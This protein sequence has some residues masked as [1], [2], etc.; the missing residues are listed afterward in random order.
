MEADSFAYLRLKPAIDSEL[1]VDDAKE[2]LSALSES[3]Q[4][5]FKLVIKSAETN[6]IQ[7]YLASSKDNLE[8]LKHHIYSVCPNV[9]IEEVKKSEAVLSKPDSTLIFKFKNHF[10]YPFY[11]PKEAD[12]EALL[13]T[14]SRVNNLNSSEQL[15]I[16]LTSATAHPIRAVFIRRR[17]L[18][19]YMPYLNDKTLK[20]YIAKFFFLLFFVLSSAFK[21][22]FLLANN[23]S[24]KPNMSRTRLQRQKVDHEE[25]VLLLDKLYEPLFKTR[26]VV[27][28]K[29][30]KRRLPKIRKEAQLALTNFAGSCGDQQLVI[31]DYFGPRDIYSLS[32]L[33][34]WLNFTKPDLKSGIY[35]VQ[36]FKTLPIP[37][38]YKSKK[39]PGDVVVGLNTYQGSM[40][41]IILPKSARY[42]HAYITGATGSG[43]S[44][45]LANLISQD[46]ASGQGATLI[47]PHGDLASE[48]MR[49][50]PG[51]RQKDVIYFDPSSVK[52]SLSINLLETRYAPGTENYTH[53]A[54][55]LTEGVISLFRKVF[56]VE[57]VSSHRLE[58]I[59]RNS[60]RTAL[61]IP[62]SN[63]F[64]I[65]K[66]LT[67]SG[68]RL[69][70]TNQLKDVNLINFWRNELGRAGE[71]QRVKMT[72]GVTSK[73]GRFLFSEPTKRVFGQ[74]KSNLDIRSVMESNKVLICNFSKGKLGEDGSRLFATAMLTKIQLAALSRADT[75]A[76]YR[77]DHFVYIDE[78]QNYAPSILI[79]MLS[80]LR[81]YN[82]YLAMA[83]QSPSQQNSL[84]TNIVLANI[85]NLICFRTAS[86]ND[87]DLL[88]PSF[89]GYL[90]AADLSNLPAYNFYL[91][92]AGEI[93]APPTSGQT[94]SPAVKKNFNLKKEASRSKPE[95][96]R[97]IEAR[98][99]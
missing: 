86:P 93:V 3:A 12:N 5:Q 83:E 33:A 14:L 92:S 9:T 73:I 40:K 17:L 46:I 26:L 87:A 19:G 85:G 44:T 76:A 30:G 62:G 48:V 20:G 82:L 75:A 21:A 36:H 66:L 10:A 81:K 63:I 95:P 55:M 4:K 11:N 53:E 99:I 28:I 24:A 1:S 25:S 16:C 78:F 65:F 54:E 94:I 7:F 38:S 59:L 96:S 57:D 56:L 89:S 31:K 69:D 68:F 79:Q 27:D 80:E 61:N 41:E 13:K 67:D 15:V 71:Y 22:V 23:L 49:N 51:K 58:Y 77:Q 34:A 74:T 84:S 97:F 90:K 8:N 91:K 35:D 29:A 72:S 42:R 88:L 98:A 50:I 6:G 43:K 32:D 45:L 64:T 2:V 18:N 39:Q 52:T 47:D 70:V 37:K 60:I